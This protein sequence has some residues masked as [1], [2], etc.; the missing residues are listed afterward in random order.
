MVFDEMVL[1]VC[2]QRYSI[3]REAVVSLSL[4]VDGTLC[5]LLS[6]GLSLSLYLALCRFSPVSVLY[7]LLQ[8]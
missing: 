7:V 5:S 8:C 1:A 3:V 2:N 6:D 4:L